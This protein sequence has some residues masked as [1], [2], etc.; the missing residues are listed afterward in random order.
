[1][2]AARLAG[3]RGNLKI[4]YHSRSLSCVHIVDGTDRGH[5]VLGAKVPGE[6]RGIR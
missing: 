2:G 3:G 4:P 5:S 6:A 1:M